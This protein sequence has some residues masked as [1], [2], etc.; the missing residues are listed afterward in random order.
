M[1]SSNGIFQLTVGSRALLPGGGGVGVTVADDTTEPQ[2][3][4]VHVVVVD[5]LFRVTENNQY[6]VC[7]Q[8]NDE[9]NPE[10]YR[11]AMRDDVPTE[12]DPLLD[13]ET[14]TVYADGARNTWNVV[15]IG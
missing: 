15:A 2:A 10:Y 4:T 13:G 12:V 14:I 6:S 3:V 1:E 8:H 5:G 11:L 7:I 9:I